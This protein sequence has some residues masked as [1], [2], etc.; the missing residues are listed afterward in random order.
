MQQQH[1]VNVVAVATLVDLSGLMVELAMQHP[2]KYHSVVVDDVAALIFVGLLIALLAVWHEVLRSFG[3]SCF[4]MMLVALCLHLAT[5]C[6][7][8][9]GFHLVLS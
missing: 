7:L 1:S 9:A 6:V 2:W 8:V 4:V 5:A 3:W